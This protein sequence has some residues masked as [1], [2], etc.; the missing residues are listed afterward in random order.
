MAFIRQKI[1][2][3]ARTATTLAYWNRLFALFTAFASTSLV[4]IS[5]DTYDKSQSFT[6]IESA[7]EASQARQDEIQFYSKNP[8]YKTYLDIQNSNDAIAF[9]TSYISTNPQSYIAKAELLSIYCGFYPMIESKTSAVSPDQRMVILLATYKANPNYYKVWSILSSCG[10]TDY[11]NQKISAEIALKLNDRDKMARQA[12]ATSLFSEGNAREALKHTHFL[13]DEGDPFFLGAVGRIFFFA[14]NSMSLEK[15]SSYLT[16]A[17]SILEPLARSKSIPVKRR[18]LFVL[19]DAY[20]SMN[21]W[22]LVQL[23]TDSLESLNALS[24][25]Q[26][27][28]FRGAIA[29]HAN[30]IDECINAV[31]P[32]L[33]L[34]GSLQAYLI[35]TAVSCYEGKGN[36]AKVL[37]LYTSEYDHQMFIDYEDLNAATNAAIYL[38]QKE[39]F[40][41][42]LRS[43]F[44]AHDRMYGL[45]HAA[46]ALDSLEGALSTCEKA[47][48]TK[49]VTACDKANMAVEMAE[50]YG[51][52]M[53]IWAKKEAFYYN[54]AFDNPCAAEKAHILDAMYA[55]LAKFERKDLKNRLEAMIKAYPEKIYPKTFYARYL[56]EFE[57]K[58][59]AALSLIKTIS[60]DTLSDDERYG[61]YGQ[62]IDTYV[63]LKDQKSALKAA[64]EY[65]AKNPSPDALYLKVHVYSFQDGYDKSAKKIVDEIGKNKS[66]IATQG[67]GESLAIIEANALRALKKP[68]AAI[69]VLKKA[70]P[71]SGEGQAA[72]NYWIART[73][74]EDKKDCA[75][76]KPYADKAWKKD[77]Q[78][79]G[80]WGWNAGSASTEISLICGF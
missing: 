54:A 44:V 9:L 58:A 67:Y 31:E 71:T 57:N 37:D 10:F 43:K 77:Y 66:I 59:D 4:A 49:G 70:L 42:F 47:Y 75:S 5:V 65:L 50:A 25:L 1:V 60:P 76:A 20:M 68:D 64:D 14:S 48:A 2:K 17:V 15:R 24:P 62:L 29:L 18:A 79:F 39:K 34:Q 26:K 73:Y 69:E 51:K 38:D 13:M 33:K 19:I 35:S 61:Y 30:K 41:S 53:G 63:A 22:E 7:K 11:K 72:H 23:A 8:R 28:Y 45:C 32:A 52:T 27:A 36:L 6:F 74:A 55:K 21:R 40:L 78:K 12:L 3:K 16:K 80:S 46:L 56:I